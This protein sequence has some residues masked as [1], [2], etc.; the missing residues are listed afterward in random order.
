V[1]GPIETYAPGQG[2]LPPTP[3]ELELVAL[4]AP[5]APPAPSPPVPDAAL[6]ELTLGPVVP[7]LAA[8]DDVDPPEPRVPVDELSVGPAQATARRTSGST[9]ADRQ[10][11]RM[12]AR[13]AAGAQ[14]ACSTPR[15]SRVREL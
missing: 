2:S 1:S 7:E 11:K 13:V 5:P 8:S 6:L 14:N 4:P 12:A 15:T 10:G 3:V 9:A